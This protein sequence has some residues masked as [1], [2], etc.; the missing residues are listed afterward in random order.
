MNSNSPLPSLE[1]YQSTL[2]RTMQVVELQLQLTQSGFFNDLPTIQRQI[3]SATSQI[4]GCRQ[5][6]MYL[7]DQP[8]SEW[9]SRISLNADGVWDYQVVAL[10]SDEIVKDCSQADGILCAPL[11][12]NHAIQGS[13]HAAEKKSGDFDA[14]DQDYLLL[15]SKIASTTISTYL[16]IQ[17][18]KELHTGT[19]TSRWELASSRNTMRALF[20]NSPTALYIVDRQYRLV[21][22]NRKRADLINPISEPLIGQYCYQ[23]LFQRSS[24]CPQCRVSRDFSKWHWLTKK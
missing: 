10:E 20:E 18:L 12:L 9:F 1:E 21:A 6:A 5:V 17:A 22:V 2:N 23:A 11:V 13:I 7:L 19:Q 4:L 8:G 14:S 15:L 16:Q 24:P 3:L